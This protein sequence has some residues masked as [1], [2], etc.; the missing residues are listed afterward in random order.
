MVNEALENRLRLATPN[1]GIEVEMIESDDPPPQASY[2][3]R[4]SLI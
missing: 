3:Q 4:F 2:R 1:V